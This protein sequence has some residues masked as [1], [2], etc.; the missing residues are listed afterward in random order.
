MLKERPLSAACCAKGLPPEEQGSQI[1]A[2]IKK[3]ADVG[4]TD[5]NGVTPLLHA[6][7]FRSPIAVE[8]LLKHG[9]HVNHCCKRS[10][11]TALHRAIISTGAP[12]TSGKVTERLEIIRKL[13]KA[14][15]DPS[16][17]NKQGKV[18]LDYAKDPETQSLLKS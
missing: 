12:G 15:A 11:S 2:L 7:R 14:G 8:L 10:G 13:L 4:E 3:G 1:L 16:I 5:K 6:V 17:K 18:P 9:A